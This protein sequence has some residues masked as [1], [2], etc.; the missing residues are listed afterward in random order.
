ME[1]DTAK[2][3]AA[4]ATLEQTP[5]AGALVPV[6]PQRQSITAQMKPS[7]IDTQ[8]MAEMIKYAELM[9]KSGTA[10]PAHL[11]DKVEMCWAVC[12][13]A[14]AWGFRQPLFLANKTYVVNDRL[15][16]E[17][18]ALNAAVL[19]MAP[20]EGRPRYEY[21]G[22]GPTRQCTALVLFRGESA[23]HDYTTP[24]FKDIKIKN[25]PLWVNDLDQQLSYYAIRGLAR[26]H[27]P[28]VLIGAITPE[29]ASEIPV[30]QPAANPN[31]LERLKGARA[32]DGTQGFSG[33]DAIAEELK[34][35]A[36]PAAGEGPAAG[37]AGAPASAK[38]AAPATPTAK[39]A[40]AA[41]AAKGKAATPAKPAAAAKGAKKPP[42]PAKAPAKAKAEPKAP[43]A[44]SA[45]PAAPAEPAAQAQQAAPPVEHQEPEQEPEPPAPAAVEYVELKPESEPASAADY[46]VWLVSWLPQHTTADNVMKQWM[47]ERKMRNTAGITS[48]ERA[49]LESARDERM[50]TLRAE[51]GGE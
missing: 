30:D 37:E 49:E 47:A 1:T 7:F 24:M 44:A 46:A 12:E 23:P 28:D 14:F 6:Q 31:L 16:F 18:Q 43:V 41:P 5:E 36:A 17:A 13:Y 11:R 3:A 45:K 26:R 40:P 4:A 39:K 34:G 25:S 21:K 22:E 42:T 33:V 20:I 15:A 27:C 8:T 51:A 38:P 19:S 35:A 32:G 48:Q 50:A 9:A 29:E 2:P 10:V